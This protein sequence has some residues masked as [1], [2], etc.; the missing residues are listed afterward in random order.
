MLRRR[1]FGAFLVCLLLLPIAQAVGHDHG[2]SNGGP[3]FACSLDHHQAAV[4]GSPDPQTAFG[5]RGPWHQHVCLACC[6]SSQRAVEEKAPPARVV[7]LPQR[8]I[9]AQDVAMPPAVPT[10][11]GTGVRGPPLA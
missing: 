2:V 8:P 10:A 11:W 7:T 1:L 3:V 6:L 9:V 5:G 4:S